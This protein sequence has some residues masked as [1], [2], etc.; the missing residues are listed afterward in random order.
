MR[1]V[2]SK[3][4]DVVDFGT[5]R[6]R[7]GIFLLTNNSNVGPMLHRFRYI[8]VFSYKNSISPIPLD[9]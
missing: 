8:A 3:S 5:N 1:N 7:V 4:F 6:K 9:I 2:R